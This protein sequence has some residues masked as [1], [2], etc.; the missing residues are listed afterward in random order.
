MHAFQGLPLGFGVDEEDGEKLD[1][2]HD[3]EEGEG[4]SL[5]VDGDVREDVGDEA[6]GD[7]VGG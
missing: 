7:P 3:G 2:H 1:D 6:V 4:Q 5:G